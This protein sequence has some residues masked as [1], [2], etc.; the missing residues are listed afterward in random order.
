MP[1]LP[2]Q[3]CRITSYNVC[4]T[5]LLRKRGTRMGVLTL[6]DRSGRLDITLFSEAL[7][8]FEPLLEKDRRNN[9]V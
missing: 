2:T 6:D 8:R 9:F 3:A 1:F 7:E 4:Y 5:K